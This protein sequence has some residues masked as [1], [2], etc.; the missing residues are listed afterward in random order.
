MIPEGEAGGDFA[1]MGDP[2]GLPADMVDSN[3]FDSSL[4]THDV[5]K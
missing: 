5:Q 2:G 1:D 3:P 4:S